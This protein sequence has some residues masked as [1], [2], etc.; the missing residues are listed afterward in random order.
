MSRVILIG[1][2]KTKQPYVL[3]AR[4]LYKGPLFVKRRAYAEA[5]G[6]PWAILSAL[7]GLVL[8]EQTLR[9]YD[10]TVT[11]DA[12]VRNL[13]ELLAFQLRED[14]AW[15]H[16]DAVEIHAGALYV[17]A[18]MRATRKISRDVAIDVPLRGLG[19]G[20]QLAWYGKP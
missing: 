5:S 1:C 4:D 13:A 19:I 11:T 10:K 9:P 20:K 16:V 7:H 15:A 18:F 2:G 6:E 12:A 17:E 14:G 8:P 3:Q